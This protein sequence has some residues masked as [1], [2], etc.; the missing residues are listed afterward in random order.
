MSLKP[1]EADT[2]S[3]GFVLTPSFVRGLSITVDFF[4]IV[5]NNAIIPLPPETMVTNCAK[6]DSAFDCAEIN[7]D[8]TN[9]W[10]IYGGEGAGSVDEPLVN[11]S[12]LST[13]GLDVQG[14]Y[15]LRLEDTGLQNTGTLDFNFNGTYTATLTTFLPDGTGYDCVGLYGLTCTIPTPKWRHDFRV[16]WES[17]WNLQ[18]SANWRYIGGSSLDF[19]T[20]VPD[21]QD[22]AFKD[23]FPTDS[24]IDPY[25]YLDL[26]FKYRVNDKVSLRGGV[27]NVLDTV[28]PLLDS[29]SFGISAPPFGNG[30]TYPQLYDPLGRYFFLGFTADL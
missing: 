11:A 16:T 6:L 26:S 4:N 12:K 17:P 2:V 14:D 8:P 1:E 22:G 29:N 30:N 13:S 18:L 10:A 27:N 5:V 20:N 9:L 23:T 24:H 21:L 7:R 15:R 25:S 3:V 19:N 28:P